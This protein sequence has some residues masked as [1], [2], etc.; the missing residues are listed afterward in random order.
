MS[1]AM[2]DMDGENNSKDR[3]KRTPHSVIVPMIHKGFQAFRRDIAASRRSGQP[4]DIT[5]AQNAAR[6]V[7][8]R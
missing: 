3:T 5:D 2:I 8:K 7:A 4:I 6:Q 1:D